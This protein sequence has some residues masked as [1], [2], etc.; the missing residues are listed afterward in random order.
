MQRRRLLY[1]KEYYF[2]VKVYDGIEI[3][4]KK[5]A[6]R[7]EVVGCLRTGVYYGVGTQGTKAQT[8]TASPEQLQTPKSSHDKRNACT[9]L[10]GHNVSTYDRLFFFIFLI[11]LMFSWCFLDSTA[12]CR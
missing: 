6:L 3:S 9:S 4:E 5:S 12:V 1:N 7:V 10:K 2:D 11:F 8:K